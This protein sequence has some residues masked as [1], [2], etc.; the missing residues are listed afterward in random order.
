LVIGRCYDSFGDPIMAEGSM[1]RTLICALACA[2]IMAIG[3]AEAGYKK[4]IFYSFRGGQKGE[5]SLAVLVADGQ[6][7]LYGTTGLGGTA[8][9]GTVFKIT[10][11]RKETVLHSFG[12]SDGDSP[13]AGLVMDKDGNLYGTTRFGGQSEACADG[14][15][16]IFKVAP[17]LTESVLF[18]FDGADGS[19]PRSS[20]IL[21][22]RGNL[23]GT[24]YFGNSPDCY[25]GGCGL[26]FR[27]AADGTETTLLQFDNGDGAN[28]VGSLLKDRH[29]NLYG[30]ASEGG[31]DGDGTV[32]K[33]A[34]N[35]TVTVL[36]DFTGGADG[37]TPYAAVIADTA[38]NLYG[39]TVYGGAEGDGTV[40]KISP[41][42]TET[43]LYS[44]TDG[45]DGG[46]PTAPV[47]MDR[48]G[49]LY[50]TTVSG[51]QAGVGTAFRLTAGGSE[52]VLFSMIDYAF[53]GSGLFALDG[54]Y[55]GTT[56]GS[57]RYGDGMVFRVKK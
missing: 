31:A 9:E 6:G 4:D 27:L 37:G 51:G 23:Y 46:L 25:T 56:P 30:T 40:F 2:S 21:D 50:G 43:V 35:G 47:V 14:C 10:P 41:D 18:S 44:F 24:A 33:L 34:P 39:T 49:N 20:L 22:E 3:G 45:T 15:G 8:D 1:I 16:T 7:N 17:D 54:Y 13:G 38:G 42:G 52:R 57:G 29:G 32:F 55:Y 28:P 5:G 36:H 26:V 48:R 12:G 19:E 11:E 53:P